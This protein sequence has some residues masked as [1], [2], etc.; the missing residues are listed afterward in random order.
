MLCHSLAWNKTVQ[1]LRGVLSVA[2]RPGRCPHAM[3]EGSDLRL[4]SAEAQGMAFPGSP[5]GYDV[6]V[7]LGWWRQQYHATSR[8]I[9]ADLAAH[10][11]ISEAHVRHL[12]QQVSLPL[13]AC[14]ERQ[15]RD[16]L[17]TVA[18]QHGGL[19]V[20]LDGVMPQAGEPQIWFI[21]ELSSGLTLR[22]GW[23][24]PQD[25]TTFEAFLKPLTPL[26]WPILAVLS[27]KQTGLG[28]ALAKV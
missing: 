25:Q 18:K 4:L 23:L 7:R 22:S 15:H 10:V 13:L 27:A 8:E 12:H 17:A 26:E 20:A 21:R 9:H 5:Y 2:S 28:P 19:I 1:T 14:H 11:H 6:V 3:C 16:R 24:S